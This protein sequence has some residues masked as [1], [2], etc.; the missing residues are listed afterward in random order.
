MSADDL[1]SIMVQVTVGFN[2]GDIG[3]VL[4]IAHRDYIHHNVDLP[5]VRSLEE[6]RQHLTRFVAAF[7]NVQIVLE[8]MVAEGS[9][10]AGMVATRVVF[11]VTPQA[12]WPGIAAGEPIEFRGME[13]YRFADGKCVEGWESNNIVHVLE[14]LGLM[15]QA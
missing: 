14:K 11:R 1:K 10:K 13:M 7:P 4:A 8:D 6:Y 5:Q 15:A 9:P 12:N 2:Q 3:A